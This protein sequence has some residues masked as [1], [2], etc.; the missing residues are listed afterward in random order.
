MA[1]APLAC[2]RWREGCARPRQRT[3]SAAATRAASGGH[4]DHYRLLIDGELVEGSQGERIESIDPGSG[5]PVATYA[6]ATASDAE[7]A[8]GAARRAFDGGGWSR[9]TPLERAEIL[10]ELADLI[11]ADSLRLA[12]LEARDSG[13]VIGRT[14]GDVF[15]GAKFLRSMA[16]YAANHFPWREEIPFRN[17]PFHSTNHLEREPIGVCVGIIPWNFP[18]TMAI[19]KIGM[20]T[21]M[22]N[23]MVLKP[24]SDTPLSARGETVKAVVVPKAEA[25]GKVSGQE[26][27]EWASNNM[28]AYKYPRIVEFVESL[29]KGA[30]GKVNWRA[31]QEREQAR[32]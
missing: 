15:M 7:A 20:A 14:H 21:I 25:P 8:V 26:I 1:W 29:Q 19:W 10:L 31:L 23:T 17:F 3:I 18:F 16:N 30:T 4:L 11:Q 9:K 6:L 32:G 27:I 2:S 13:G 5:R 24:A 22:G 28:A 12:D